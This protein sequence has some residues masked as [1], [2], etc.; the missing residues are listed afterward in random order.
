MGLE[1][2]AEDKPGGA[3]GLS[4]DDWDMFGFLMAG[5]TTCSPTACDTSVAGGT[6]KCRG[7]ASFGQGSGPPGGGPPGSG[8][9]DDTENAPDDSV[10]KDSRCVRQDQC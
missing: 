1:S 2:Y 10:A 7:T 5:S 8:P 6:F 4:Q 9:P 3:T